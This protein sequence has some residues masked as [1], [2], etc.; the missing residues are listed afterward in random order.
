MRNIILNDLVRVDKR[1]A[2]KLFN[3]GVNV[4]LWACKANIFSPWNAYCYSNNTECEFDT[5]VNAFEYYNCNSQIGKYAKYYV[6]SK[7]LAR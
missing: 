2:R 3:K 4:F 7:D 6:F 5:F 1:E